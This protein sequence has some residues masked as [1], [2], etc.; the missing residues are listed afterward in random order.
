MKDISLFV[1]GEGMERKGG[2][3]RRGRWLLFTVEPG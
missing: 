3:R 1:L 2:L